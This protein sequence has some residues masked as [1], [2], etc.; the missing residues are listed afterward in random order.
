MILADYIEHGRS[1]CAIIMTTGRKLHCERETGGHHHLKK[2]TGSQTPDGK[3]PN[4]SVTP[5]RVK[6]WPS[7]LEQIPPSPVQ[8]TVKGL[9]ISPG[10]TRTHRGQ[11]ERGPGH[12]NLWSKLRE[13][14]K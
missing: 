7:I 1:S 11:P 8:R 4:G 9:D 13:G 10:L 2:T 14:T 5:S 12:T 3:I 6:I